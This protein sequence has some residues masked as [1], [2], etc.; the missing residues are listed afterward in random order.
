MIPR[1]QVSLQDISSKVKGEP[2]RDAKGGGD[3]HSPGL[4]KICHSFVT[5]SGTF[6]T[7]LAKHGAFEKE[8]GT[9]HRSAR[10]HIETQMSRWY[11]R[12]G[13]TGNC[14]VIVICKGKK[15]ICPFARCVAI[16]CALSACFV[17]FVFLCILWVISV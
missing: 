8:A 4:G 9:R 2:R 15:F 17:F 10:E 14:Q 13:R 5:T 16:L 6:S 3:K 7:V 1:L 12:N 11:R